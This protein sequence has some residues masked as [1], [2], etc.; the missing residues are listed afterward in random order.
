VTVNANFLFMNYPHQ[1]ASGSDRGLAVRSY[2][3]I[4][5]EHF[6]SCSLLFSSL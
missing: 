6:Q 2:Q 5:M 3:T 1:C 4:Y